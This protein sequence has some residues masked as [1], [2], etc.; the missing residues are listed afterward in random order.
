MLHELLALT[1]PLI[2]L[3]TETTGTYPAW[4]RI[5]ELALVKIHPDGRKEVFE[6]RV[7]PTVPIPP[8]ASKIHGIT[9]ADVAS[10]PPFSDIAR[11][12]VDFMAGC[13]F[14]GFNIESFDLPIIQIELER[15]GIEFDATGTVVIDAQ[16]IFHKEESRT[17]SDAVRL[18]VGGEHENAHNALA[19]VEATARVLEGQLR[20]YPH[21]AHDPK[22]LA[23]QY[24]PSRG[25][26]VDPEGKFVSKDGV[27]FVNF[28]KH[29]G[30]SFDQV[31]A[32]AAS[33]FEWILKGE[34]SETVKSCVRGYLSS[35]RPPIMMPRRL[36]DRGGE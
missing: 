30:K 22:E 3:D 5:V 27:L 33:Y 23:N 13:D 34:F 19:D 31:Y 32:E 2:V 36:S 12:L 18:Y 29:R 25:R 20:R 4:D 11:E 21:M 24:S 14:A 8:D 35:V 9:D 26:R 7:N 1:R 17:L 28:G 15:A 6:R 16:L 10:L